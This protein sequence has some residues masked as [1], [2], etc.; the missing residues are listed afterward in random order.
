MEINGRCTFEIKESISK[1]GSKYS[2]I[3]FKIG[4]YELSRC[5]DGKPFF[6]TSDQMMLIQLNA[7]KNV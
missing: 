1:K 4:E 5:A 7:K 3:V 2:H 6:L